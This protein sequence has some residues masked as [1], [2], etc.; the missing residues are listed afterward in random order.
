[1]TTDGAEMSDVDVVIVGGGVAGLAAALRL[2]DWNAA[3]PGARIS[4][5]VLEKQDRIG[6]RTETAP[7]RPDIDLGAAFVGPLQTYTM[8]LLERLGIPLISNDLPDGLAHIIQFEDSSAQYYDNESFPTDQFYWEL[9]KSLAGDGPVPGSPVVPDAIG[10]MDQIVLDLKTFYLQAPW[11]MPG[12][13]A[14]DQLS[15]TDFMN[16]I[17][18]PQPNTWQKIPPQLDPDTLISSFFRI[19]PTLVTLSV[20]E[21]KP[22]PN[23][24]SSYQ[25]ARQLLEI[26]VRSALSVEPDKLSALYFLY[27]VTTGGSFENVMTIGGGADAHRLAYGT[28]S[29]IEALAKAIGPSHIRM[30]TAVE[31]IE[32][33]MAHG[34]EHVE[35]RTR[36]S[37]GTPGVVYRARHAIVAMSPPLSARLVYEHRGDLPP[38]QQAILKLRLG[39]CTEAMTMGRTIK[40]FFTY[41]SPWW[42]YKPGE[43]SRANCSGYTLS[44]KG[45]IDWTMD[46]SWQDPAGTLPDRYSLMAFIVADRADQLGAMTK[47]KRRETLV[48][49]LVELFGDERARAWTDYHEGVWTRGAW[50]EGCPAAVFTPGKFVPYGQALRQPW[51]PVHWAGSESATDWIGGYMNGAIQSGIRAVLEILADLGNARG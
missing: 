36:A 49:H 42:R 27:Y 34:G 6:G 14:L 23:V 24:F 16:Q 18:P 43:R 46:N 17:S 44:A 19:D 22:V 11:T 9:L 48:E 47:E 38:D 3:N 33:C 12:A 8:T 29:L 7:G 40:A 26:S 20:D 25:V 51:G 5:V 45:P 31:S 37:G 39:L 41:A 28:R 10:A 21:T 15:V 35:V 30:G 1:M 2:T 4:F 32:R 50:S 13:Q